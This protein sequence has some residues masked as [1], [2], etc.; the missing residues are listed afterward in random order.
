VN[1]LTA[2]S[3]EWNRGSSAGPKSGTPF[4]A[5]PSLVGTGVALPIL[6]N[7]RP[8]QEL[9]GDLPDEGS[10]FLFST[11]GPL[12][13]LLVTRTRARRFLVLVLVNPSVDDIAFL[14][15]HSFLQDRALAAW[16]MTPPPFTSWL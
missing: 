14:R 10:V 16:K 5:V 13:L 4:P 2:S 3:F 12:P 8:A 11:G 1:G 7:G 6:R 9:N 15:F